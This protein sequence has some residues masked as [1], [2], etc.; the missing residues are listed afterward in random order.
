MGEGGRGNVGG[1]P[2]VTH[3]W[4]GGVFTDGDK[5]SLCG[6]RLSAMAAGDSLREAGP[7]DCSVCNALRSPAR[8]VTRPEFAERAGKVLAAAQ[9]PDPR[10]ARISF[11]E[12]KREATKADLLMKFEDDD[13]HGTAD[14]AM[15]LRDIDSELK[16][17]RL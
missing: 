2:A 15:D 14:A 3:V 17:L 13:W 4:S 7:V 6:L 12:R 8:L 1:G 10:T 11:L 16:G 9:E 5:A